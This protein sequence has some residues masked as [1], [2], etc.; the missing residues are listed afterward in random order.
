MKNVFYIHGAFA[1]QMS[2]NF[3]FP[4]LPEH[5]HAHASYD[6]NVYT[7]EQCIELTRQQAQNAFKGES[8]SVIGHSIGGVIAKAFAIRGEAIEKLITMS[9]PFGGLYYVRLL[10]YL[11]RSRTIYDDLIHNSE[12]LRTIRETAVDVPHLNMI[13][14]LGNRPIIFKE[15]DTIV[16][17]ESMKEGEFGD[18]VKFQEVKCNHAEILVCPE[19]VEYIREFLELELA[20]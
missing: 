12:P 15:N 13:T 20:T 14:V 1:S 3:L 2:F 5:K 9:A 19:T 8:Y 11:S 17:V 7:L 10:K 18:H 16:P 6:C 4:L